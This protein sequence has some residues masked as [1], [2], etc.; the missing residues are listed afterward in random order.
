MVQSS[1][2]ET[3]S[4][5]QKLQSVFSI[6][7]VIFGFDGENLKVLLIERDE[8][9]FKD[10][11][12]IPGDL[13]R[14]DQD[15]EPAAAIILQS[16][17]G[18]SDIYM[19]QLHTFGKVNRH[20]M[21]RIITVAYYALVNIEE[22][23]PSPSSFARSIGWYSLSNLPELAFDHN[24]IIEKAIERLQW[25]LRTQPIGFELLPDKF[26]LSQLRRLYEA[27]LGVTMDKRNFRRKILK[28]D[29]LVATD[30]KQQNVA[31]KAARYYTFDNAKYKELSAEGYS[32]EI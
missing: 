22:I 20:P 15:L 1:K 29:L 6:D 9:P 32:F 5:M 25:K 13:V 2:E 30:E 10:Y 16:L 18:L 19:E 11:I 31:H 8:M 12:A 24:F 27:I 21:G 23:N 28:T 3:V 7:C 14:P 4:F 26:T 17:T